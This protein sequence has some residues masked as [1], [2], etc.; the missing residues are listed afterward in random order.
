MSGA[1]LLENAL[2]AKKAEYAAGIDDAEAFEIFSAETLLKEFGL[3]YD[4]IEQGVVDGQN[5][6]GID[7]CYVFIN[8]HLLFED[9]ELKQF[10]KP[11]DIQIHVIQSKSGKG[12]DEKTVD[13]LGTSL[14]ALLNLK[15]NEA[16]LA[17]F[18]NQEV[19]DK[20]M[21]CRKAMVGLAGE[22][23]KISLHIHYCSLSEATNAKAEARAKHV[24]DSLGK[25]LSGSPN[26]QFTFYGADQLYEE[27]QKQALTVMKLPLEKAP[28]S[29]QNGMIALVALPTFAKFISSDGH[30]IDNLFEYNVRDYQG[31]VAVN[32]EISETLK[33]KDDAV[34]F[35]H[36]NNGVTM[37]AND[38]HYGNDELTIENPLIV[39]GLQTSNEIFLNV[40]QDDEKDTRNL[41]LKV[42]KIPDGADRDRVVKATNFQTK[43]PEASLHA[44]EPI[45][46]KIEDFLEVSQI[47]YD[48]RK[49]SW[50]NKGKPASSII[51]IEKLAQAVMTVLLERPVDARARPTSLI[52]DDAVYAKLFSDDHKLDVYKVCAEFHFAIDDYIRRHR[53]VYH[54]IFR[55]NL[56]YYLMMIASWQIAKVKPISVEALV[57]LNVSLCTDDLLGK[58]MLW[59]MNEFKDAG[60][61]DNTAKD[62][63]FTQRLKDNWTGPLP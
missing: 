60:A 15:V 57:H 8:R 18:L 25:L 58:C 12:F 19:I 16:E 30:L 3:T 11:V 55:N 41:L 62:A 44:S 54:P 10:K 43:V 4:D 42:L 39:N 7:S 23:P 46:R 21:H 56:R 34:D 38:V 45:H 32:K 48:R 31:D 17:Q 27:A 29:S 40:P 53:K 50:R 5:D 2:K 20:F 36:L 33:T 9:T 52:K 35:W 22:F 1:I 6:G 24:C 59:V 49:K 37:V 14:T 26:I 13:E 63:R 28:L 47:Y 61:A 51:G